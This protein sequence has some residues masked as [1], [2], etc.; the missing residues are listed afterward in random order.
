MFLYRLAGGKAASCAGAWIAACLATASPSSAQD[1]IAWRQTLNLP[2]GLNLPAGVKADILG[3]ALGEPYASAQPKLQALLAESQPPHAFDDRRITITM[4]APGGTVRVQGTFNGEINV[5]RRLAGSTNLKILE[6]IAVHF[7]APSSGNQVL[8]IR[9][10]MEY[11]RQ[12]EP[13]VS[14]I[15]ARLTE[16]FGS[17]PQIFKGGPGYT[18]Y[19]WQF[20]DGQAFVPP[21]GTLSTD[22]LNYHVIE[23]S[24]NLPIANRTGNCDVVMNLDVLQGISPDH[25]R[26]LTFHLSDNERA[27][28]NVGADYAFFEEYIN[29][30]AKRSS[31]VAPRL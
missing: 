2:M 28:R 1:Q 30:L 25:A 11:E 19:R 9:R 7:S 3:V 17:Q 31:G 27:K 23:S 26:S 13:R 12:D 10:M 14:E 16:K 6:T 8:G 20:N 15:V 29:D 24:Q 21:R 4:G 18:Q 5:R 22:C